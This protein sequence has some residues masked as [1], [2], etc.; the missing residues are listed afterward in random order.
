VSKSL[1]AAASRKIAPWRVYG[2]TCSYFTGKLEGYL[3]YKGIPYEFVS[4]TSRHWNRVVPRATGAMQM[5]AV[6]LPDGRWLTDTTPILGWVETQYPTPVVIP[7]DPV[8]AF[9]SRLVEDYADEW[10]WRPAMHY[11]WSHR[12]DARLMSH[13]LAAEILSDVPAPLF[14]RRWIIYARQR[15]VFVWR[16]GVTRRTRAHVEGIYLRT[17]AALQA[18]VSS[19]PF[20]LG[21]VPTLADFGFFGSMFRHFASDPT[22]RAIMQTRAPAVYEWVARVWNAHGR[23]GAILDDVPAD[24]GPILEDVGSGY[25]P[26]LCANAEAWKAGRPRFDVAVQGT[27]YRHVPTSRYRVWC[28]ETLRRHVDALPD[29]A[30]ARVRALLER[31]GCWDPLWR[32]AD[33]RSGH[34]PEHL[35]PFARGL[36]VF[37]EGSHRP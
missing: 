21:D 14:V 29:A 12:A 9:V 7:H 10:L 4:M 35:A 1:P 16:D 23:R 3:R 15:G 8:T 30:R 18:I 24:W 31:H 17:L 32:V 25:L 36:A 26:Y 34:D 28:L 6:T 20:L 19:R 5:P 22:A 11:R 33:C 27:T 2:S 13:W 37:A